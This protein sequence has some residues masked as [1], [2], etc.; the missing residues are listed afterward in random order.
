M[1][2]GYHQ[3]E[4]FEPHKE[5]TAFT[6]GPLGFYEF[7]R[8]PFGLVNAPAIYQRLMEECFFGLHLDICYI[9][10]D[11]LIIFSKT[12]DEHVERLEKIFNRLREVNVKLSRKKCEFFK[13]KVRYVGHIVSAYG[14]E[15][16]PQ[17]VEKVKD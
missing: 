5:R 6:L 11:D 4:L 12:F 16:D 17:K 9:Y 7:N 1:K 3:I 13:K 15:P 10:L 8:M 2:S 14:I